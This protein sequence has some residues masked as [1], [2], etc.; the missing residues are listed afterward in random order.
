M[1]RLNVQPGVLQALVSGGAG[2]REVGQHGGEEGGKVSCH[3]TLPVVLLHQH[4]L[5][6][7]AG[8]KEEVNIP[9]VEEL[10]R[11]VEYQTGDTQKQEATFYLKLHSS[12]HKLHS[13][14]IPEHIP[15]TRVGG[16]GCAVV[17]LC[18]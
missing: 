5:Q 15:H 6:T 11:E 18:G 16:G 12:Y 13:T 14:Y 17:P 9:V 4:V 2:R 10:I 3:F 7:P 1:K 8:R